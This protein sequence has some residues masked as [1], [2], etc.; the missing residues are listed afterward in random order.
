[1]SHLIYHKVVA[2]HVA[3]HAFRWFTLA[4]SAEPLILILMLILLPLNVITKVLVAT[5]NLLYMLF[6]FPSVSYNTWAR[7]ITLELA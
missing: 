2:N 6:L 1:M 7:V 3:S 5:Q 4:T